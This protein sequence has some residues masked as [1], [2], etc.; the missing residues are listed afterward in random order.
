MKTR[1]ILR[2]ITIFLLGFLFFQG[3]FWG[4][5]MIGNDS[6]DERC[7]GKIFKKITSVEIGKY[8]ASDKFIMVID[9][10]DRGRRD[11]EVSASTFVSHSEG[12]RLCFS[13]RKEFKTNIEAIIVFC[14]M[15]V[16]LVSYIVLVL[17]III[18][19][20]NGICWLLNTK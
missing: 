7:C 8:T 4:Y 14:K 6:L 20:Y 18:L 12:D 10:D 15:I 9:F 19:A 11:L 16:A 17:G 13:L 5:D 1:K 3:L 2:G